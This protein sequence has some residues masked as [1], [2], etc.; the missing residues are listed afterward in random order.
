MTSTPSARE[1]VDMRAMAASPFMAAEQ[2]Y[3]CHDDYG[4]GHA[5][6]GRAQYRCYCQRPEAHVGQAVPYHGIPL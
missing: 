3:R 1:P 6:L 2:Q 5:Q 4:Y